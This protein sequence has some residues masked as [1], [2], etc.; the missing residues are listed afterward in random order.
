M[1]ATPE[2][3]AAKPAA[4]ELPP[5]AVTPREVELKLACSAEA[6]SV[7]RDAELIARHA[8]NRG[9][10]RRLEATACSIVT[11]CPCACAAAD[12]AISRL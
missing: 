11:A 12:G 2:Q 5:P 3:D 1:E 7:L 4:E 10:V 6:L 8:R 9:I